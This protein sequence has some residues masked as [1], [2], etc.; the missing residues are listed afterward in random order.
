LLSKAREPGAHRC[1]SLVA[2]SIAHGNGTIR[3]LAIA[4]HENVGT[5]LE[6]GIANSGSQRLLP[7]VELD[8]KAILSNPLSDSTGRGVVAFCDRKHPCLNGSQPYGQGAA[9]VLEEDPKESLQ[10]A[11]E[12]P[13]QDK[14]TVGGAVASHA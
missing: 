6:C 10:R 1:G 14:R 13:V 7:I 4:E 9:V 12:R 2:A 11:E 5:L 3:E 8:V